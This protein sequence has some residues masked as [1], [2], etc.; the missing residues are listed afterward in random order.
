MFETSIKSSWTILISQIIALGQYSVGL[1]ILNL[2]RFTTLFVVCCL[3]HNSPA[4]AE[5]S[6]AGGSNYVAIDLPEYLA[7]RSFDWRD[8]TLFKTPACQLD[9]D[10]SRASQELQKMFSSGQRKIALVL[11]HMHQPSDQICTGFALNSF[12][13]RFPAIVVQ[14]VQNFAK[15][16][17]HIGFSEFEVRFAPLAGNS[18]REWKTWNIA[19]FH[20][21]WEIIQQIKI[22][23]DQIKGITITYDLGVELGGVEQE[24]CVECSAYTSNIWKLFTQNFG[25]LDTYGFSIAY[26]RGRLARLIQDLQQSS[27]VLPKAFAVDLYKNI[28]PALQDFQQEAIDA[29][30]SNP[31]FFIQE[32]YYNDQNTFAQFL[33][34]SK[35]IHIKA[36]MQ[37][38]REEDSHGKSIVPHQYKYLYQKK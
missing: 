32:T 33:D 6:E 1:T 15:M 38:P 17:A 16:A 37:W 30:D 5:L 7:D 24:H 27:G 26:R 28:I 23:L 31:E 4:F 3:A 25:S 2:F 10:K 34:A 13:G 36:V 19:A 20:E 9:Q 22:A 21:N 18:P 29:G 11:W 35:F 12:R 14:N 8:S